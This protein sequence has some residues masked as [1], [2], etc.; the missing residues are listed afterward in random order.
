MSEPKLSKEDRVKYTASIL[1]CYLADGPKPYDDV[2]THFERLGVSR[3]DLKAARKELQV[4]T[5]NTGKTWLWEVPVTEDE[6]Y[7]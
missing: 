2:K 4:R 6:A 3:F 7:A 1:A 5:I